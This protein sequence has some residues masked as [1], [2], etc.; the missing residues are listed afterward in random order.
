MRQTLALMVAALAA[1]ASA[2]NAAPAVRYVDVNSANATPPYTNWTTAAVTIQDAIDAAN[3]GDE[4]VVTNGVYQTGGRVVYGAMTNRVAVTKPMTVKSVNGSAV[5]VIEGSSP[6]GNNA[7]RCVYLTNGATLIGFTLTNG[8]TRAAGDYSREQSGGGVWCESASGIVSNCVLTGNFAIAGGGAFRCTLNKCVVTGNLARDA[9]GGAVYSD[10][11]NCTLRSNVV[12]SAES[13]YGGGAHTVVGIN[14]TITENSSAY[15][16]G[17]AYGSILK[18]SIVYYN[19]APAGGENRSG[20]VMY[21]C[22][23]IPVFT[24]P[25]SFDYDSFGDAPLLDENLRLQ[26]NSPCID[27]GN[28]D[29]VFSTTDLAGLRRIADGTVDLGAYEYQGRYRLHIA[30]NAG[31]SVAQEPDIAEH[32]YGSMVTVSAAS[33]LG[34]GFI[35]W[36]GDAIGSTNPLLVLMDTHKSIAAV[37]ASTALTLASEGAGA[38]SRAPD[39]AYYAVGDEVLLTATADRWHVFAGWSDGSTDNPRTVIIGETNAYTAV[40]IPATSLDTVTIG[41]ISR[42]APVG[43]PAVVVDGLF[44]LTPSATAR[45]SALVELSTT[46]PS[47]TLLY[48][49]D[50]SDPAVSGSLYAGPFT[51]GMSGLLRTIAYNVDFT[52]S[53]PGDAVSIVILPTL[54][55]VTEGGGT[56]AVEP[57][58]GEYFSNSLAVVTATPA[59]GWTFLQWLDDASG[60]NPVVNLTMTRTKTVRAV[61]GTALNTVTVGSGSIVASPVSPL[62]PHG[63]QVQLT[64]VPA[65]GNYHAFWANAAAGGTNNP[66]TFAVTNAN[67]T[68][69]AVFASIGSAQT[70]TLTVIPDGRGQVTLTPPGNRYRLNSNVVLHATADA[71]QEFLG[72]SGAA[73]GS[74]NPL[75]VAMNTSKVITA[76][77]TTRPW[78]RGEGNP[79][80]LRQDGF[81]LTVTGEF[82]ALYQVLGSLDFS[83]WT[84]LGTV[85][86]AWGTVQFTDTAATNGPFRFYRATSE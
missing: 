8:A 23:V 55:A 39:Q 25:I 41:G 65:T 22:C 34:Y 61:F 20:G 16:G 43:M 68:V 78:L 86:N 74:E 53:V 29:Y 46:F 24:G 63:S 5:T 75:T 2:L 73:S 10:L 62:Y 67:P 38:I 48:T 84:V 45:G 4:I 30:A 81:R 52:Q 59:P 69:T 49:L 31:G 58:A 35:R 7:V 19:S 51:V 18:N 21:N 85:S 71:G 9:G 44:I 83:H 13:G 72:W 50:G 70:N 26:T 64:P 76:S 14:C 28:N 79:D 32:P 47:G 82:G 36:T 15:R 40:F 1:L 56:V 12:N 17:G 6:R 60:N 11:N 57:P 80:L 33:A 27:A 37:F 77:F 42:L 54:T 3:A 66:F